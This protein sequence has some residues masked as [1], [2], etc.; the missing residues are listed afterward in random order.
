MDI[1]QILETFGLP[2]AGVIGLAYYISKKD[3]SAEKQNKYIQEELSKELRESFSRI[4]GIII[5]LINAQK[6]HSISLKALEKTYEGI[7]KII[8]K[9]SGNGLKDKFK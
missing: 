8:A 2:V 3:K 6:K 4:E 5:G 7:I 9:L 1:I